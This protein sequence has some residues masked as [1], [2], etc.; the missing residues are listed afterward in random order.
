[1]DKR[2]CVR[3]PPKMWIPVAQPAPPTVSATPTYTP[4]PT[5]TLP[6]VFSFPLPPAAPAA[7]LPAPPRRPAFKDSKFPRC[8]LLREEG[9]VYAV[10]DAAKKARAKNWMSA[11]PAAD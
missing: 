8:G 5:Y 4:P 1:M 11:L 9:G 6:P 10:L 3:D 2:Q 7:P